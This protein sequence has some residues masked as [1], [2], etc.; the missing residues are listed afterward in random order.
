MPPEL[1]GSRIERKDSPGRSDG[2]PP[3]VAWRLR[4]EVPTT[5]GYRDPG[6]PAAGP[7]VRGRP[8]PGGVVQGAAPHVA[9]RRAGPRCSANP[10]AA[11]RAHPAGRHAAAAGRTLDSLR[12]ALNQAEG[13]IREHAA[14]REGAASHA[15]AVGAV[16]CVDDDRRLG[17]LVAHRAALAT[18][19]LREFH[20]VALLC[21]A[22]ETSCGNRIVV[23][24][25]VMIPSQNPGAEGLR[26]ISRPV[27]TAERRP[28]RCRPCRLALFFVAL[29]R[30][31][32][33]DVPH[34]LS[35]R[36]PH[37]SGALQCTHPLRLFTRAHANET[38]E[39]RGMP[40]QFLNTGWVVGSMTSVLYAF[41]LSTEPA[42]H[43]GD[44]D[45]HGDHAKADS[46]DCKHV[47]PSHEDV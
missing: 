11:L 19:G 27:V 17:D 2:S 8:Q 47:S 22:A 7:D 39:S 24:V 37:K 13:P 23:A 5:L 40:N 38:R 43:T 30:E 36:T 3:G 29:D 10:H 46:E 41:S 16:A 12:F 15:L 6:L 25:K 42:A 21:S 45:G 1:P 32:G 18:A 4:L 20:R 34:L 44:G 35:T 31:C 9:H 26:R 28:E 14:E 33:A